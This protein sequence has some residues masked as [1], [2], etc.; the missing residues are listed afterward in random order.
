MVP[1]LPFAFEENCL[2]QLIEALFFL[3]VW[4]GFSRRERL[5]YVSLFWKGALPTTTPFSC[6]NRGLQKEGEFH[7]A[8]PRTSDSLLGL[9]QLRARAVHGFD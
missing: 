7:S 6:M 3:V 9:V 1:T 8:I 4:L 5:F 2:F